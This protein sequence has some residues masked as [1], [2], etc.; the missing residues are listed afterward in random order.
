MKVE[1][2]ENILVK[3]ADKAQ[4]FNDIG[5]VAGIANA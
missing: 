2:I 3:T 4:L 1:I 5:F